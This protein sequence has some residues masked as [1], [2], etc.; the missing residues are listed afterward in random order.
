MAGEHREADLLQRAGELG[1]E[2]RLVLRIAMQEAPE[3]ERRDLIVLVE[4]V[5]VLLG[6][7]I[8]MRLAH[9]VVALEV[10]G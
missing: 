1:G 10:A 7:A 2:A 8:G 5:V 3:I 9:L 6:E 4:R